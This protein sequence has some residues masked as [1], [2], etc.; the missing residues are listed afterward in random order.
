MATWKERL[1]ATPVIGSVL[2]WARLV[3]PGGW[4]FTSSCLE[5]L[6]DPALRNQLP[7]SV[8][9]FSLY[10]RPW[11]RLLGTARHY[12]VP[13]AI[14]LFTLLM[15]VRGIMGRRPIHTVRI[16]GRNVAIKVPDPRSLA[17]I[18]EQ[19]AP[20]PPLQAVVTL[21]RPGDT[22]LDIGANHGTFAMVAARI[23]GPTGTVIAFEPQPD[24]A[25]LVEI[26]LA[27]APVGLSRVHQVALGERDR[28]VVIWVPRDSSGSGTLT[29]PSGRTTRAMP[30]SVRLQ[31]LDE[32]LDD[33]RLTGLMVIKLDVEGHETAVLRGGA[34]TLQS[35]RPAIV[36]EVDGALLA[37]AGFTVEDFRDAAARGGYSVFKGT[38]RGAAPKPLSQLG[39]SAH[40]DIVLFRPDSPMGERLAELAT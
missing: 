22:F 11:L 10:V 17:V 24:L 36:C 21:L 4:I 20:G 35:H 31:T 2:R 3:S 12:H 5:W 15:W 23:V 25:R 28:E 38:E 8:R 33:A 9:M 1:K 14:Q 19:V 18:N 7:L 29:R 39:I 40:R 34:R 6:R 16:D 27:D 32:A 37:A 30:T 13:G 26:N